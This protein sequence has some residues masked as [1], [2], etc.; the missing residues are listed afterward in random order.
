MI[1]VNNKERQVKMSI[2]NGIMMID[3]RTYWNKKQ[4][5][6]ALKSKT[7]TIINKNKKLDNIDLNAYGYEL[8][9]YDKKFIEATRQ[10]IIQDILEENYSEEDISELEITLYK[11]IIVKEG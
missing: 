3:G 2:N 6:K 8:E 1:V 7:Y 11:S 10:R 9:H 5:L 4:Y